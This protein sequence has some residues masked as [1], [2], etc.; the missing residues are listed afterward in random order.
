MYADTDTDDSIPY[1]KHKVSKQY[2]L[3]QGLA[4]PRCAK[5]LVDCMT[6]AQ[7]KS[8][9]Q[10]SQTGEEWGEIKFSNFSLIIGSETS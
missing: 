9:V 4:Q 8:R 2:Y 10:I 3:K 6:F 1:T 7:W 5:H